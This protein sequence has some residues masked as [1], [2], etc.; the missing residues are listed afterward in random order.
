MLFLGRIAPVKNVDILIEAAELL[1][2]HGNTTPI[3]IYGNALPRDAKY[4]S[5]L[6]KR[7]EPLVQKGRVKFFGGIPNTEAPALFRSYRYFVNL[8]PSGSFDK[9]IIEAMS[10]GSI[11]VASNRSFEEMVEKEYDEL[12]VF[13]EQNAED[14]AKKVITLSILSQEEKDTI[15]E[16]LRTIV[17][18]QH[19]LMKLKARLEEVTT[20]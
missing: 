20:A 4:L 1:E 19:S 7:A 16:A 12:M 5:D 17:T 8:T 3:H 6:Q 14:L 18:R 11:V 15:G 13:K 9:T 2:A 10:S